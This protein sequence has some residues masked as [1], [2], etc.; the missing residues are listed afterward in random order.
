MFNSFFFI[1][2]C[3]K[4][5][6]VYITKLKEKLHEVGFEKSKDLLISVGDLI[7]R[8][9]DSLACLR[10]IEEPWFTCVMGNHEKMAFDAVNEKTDESVNHWIM[11]GGD[12]FLNLDDETEAKNLINK[13]GKLPLIIELVNE[14]KLT[15]ICHADY[16]LNEYKGVDFKD[17]EMHLLWSRERISRM[18]EG[19]AT[20]IKGADKFIF[21]HT[22]LK[23][24][25]VVAN[26]VYI[27]T[28]ACF[29][30]KLTLLQLK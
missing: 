12:W 17:Y 10:L 2:T 21:G 25:L 15:I 13:A 6:R 27:D 1:T 11:N 7:D 24:P 8:G 30:N 4:I 5:Y 9:E 22:P 16:P 20:K 23:E 28:A 19:I 14:D 29:G 18:K 3:N 26:Q